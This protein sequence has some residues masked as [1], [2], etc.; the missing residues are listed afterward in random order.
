[1]VATTF[2]ND[3][4]VVDVDGATVLVN[5]D[6]KKNVPISFSYTLSLSLSLFTNLH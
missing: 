2:D 4:E 1:M 3:Y 6:G 5:D